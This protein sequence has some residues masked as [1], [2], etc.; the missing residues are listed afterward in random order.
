MDPG[1]FLD[2]VK[3]FLVKLMLGVTRATAVQ[4]QSTIWIRFTENGVKI[5]DLAFN[6]RMLSI[7][8]KSNMDGIAGQIVTHMLNQIENPALVNSRFV[9]K[10]VLRIDINFHRFNLSRGSS[11]LPLPD[12]L[13]QKGAIINPK[14]FD[15]LYFKW[16]I[17]ATM[18]WREVGSNPQRVS[19][20]MKFESEFDWNGIG[21]PVSFK[22]IHN[23]ETNNRI[24]V[25]VLAEENKQL[26]VCRKG[27]WGH[28]CVG[29]WGGPVCCSWDSQGDGGAVSVSFAFCFGFLVWSGMG[30][31]EPFG[32]VLH[33]GRV[34]G[35]LIWKGGQ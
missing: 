12:K 17:I 16:A 9:F 11:Y 33:L 13:A 32:V 6:S 10:E 30:H 20:L 18:K 25:N 24:S 7:Y 34:A 22:N 2:K 28:M 1:T 3:K 15:L 14:N 5:V 8:N 27:A 19:K 31:G 29:I 21:F 26:Y 4:L 35:L 23:F